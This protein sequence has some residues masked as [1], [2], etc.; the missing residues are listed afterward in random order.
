[1]DPNEA[2]KIIRATMKQLQATV[3]RADD[4]LKLNIYA[5]G[6]LSEMVDAWNGLD[7]WLKKGGFPPK[8]WRRK[9]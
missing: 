6:Q 8:S 2:L 4:Y 7:D 3:D 1:M 9:R 5:I